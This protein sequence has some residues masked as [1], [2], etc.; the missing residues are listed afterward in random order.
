MQENLYTFIRVFDNVL[1]PKTLENFTKVCKESKSFSDAEIVRNNQSQKDIKVRD[2][3]TW[4]LNNS[5]EK[6]LT[7]VHWCNFFV[8]QFNNYINEYRKSFIEG[9]PFR[10]NEI[11]VLKYGVGGH[12]DFHVDHGETIPRT[13]SLIFFVNDDYEGGNLIFKKP[14]GPEQLSIEKKKNTLVIWPSNFLYPHGV[15]PV[16]SGERLSVVSWAI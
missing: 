13:I 11:Q 10:I 15:S 16:K 5:T 3:K 12:Y 9:F 8:Y 2:T 1:K 14:N 6:S 4:Y 7:A